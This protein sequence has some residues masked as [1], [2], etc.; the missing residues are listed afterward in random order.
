[1]QCVPLHWPVTLRAP[2]PAVAS[3][4]WFNGAQTG[5]EITPGAC[6]AWGCREGR[7]LAGAC[8]ERLGALRVHLGQATPC[9]GRQQR[10]PSLSLQLYPARL[11]LLQSPDWGWEMSVNP[12]H[13]HRPVQVLLVRS[14][15]WGQRASED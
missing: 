8:F 6:D 5:S 12:I 7:D 1:M 4:T 9:V 15:L 11:L 2:R 13:C 14:L 3:A 10:E